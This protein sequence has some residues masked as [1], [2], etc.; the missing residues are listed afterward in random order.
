MK[1]SLAAVF[2]ALAAA[3]GPAGAAPGQRVT[4]C[5]DV[6]PI[7]YRHC[8]GCHR[9]GEVGPF[10]LLSYKD[11]AKRADFLKQVTA[12]R[13]MP[14]WK[15]EPGY[16]DFLDAR[17]LSD[18]ELHT[19]ARWADG[20]APEGDP[21]D[22]PPPPQ[23]ADGWQLGQPDLVLKMPEPFTVPAGGRDVFRC[24]VIPTGLAE[25]R[26]VAAVEF[27][28]GN[29]RVVHHALFFL[30]SL[31]AARKRDEADPGP[32]Y[33][34]FGGIGI[35]PTG[36]LGGWAPGAQPHRLPDGVGRFL[37]KNSDLVLQIHYHTTGKEEI[38]QSSV[39]STFTKKPADK[40]LMGVV[41]LNRKVDIPPGAADY[42]LTASSTLRVDVHAIGV[43]PHMHLLGREMKVKAVRPDG[44]EVPLVWIKDWDFNWQGQYLFRAPVA[45]PRG[46]RLELEAVYDNSAAN[47]K[48]P[49]NPPKRVQWGEQTTDEMCLCG[50]HV[51]ADHP[52]D[53]LVLLRDMVL[54]LADLGRRAAGGKGSQP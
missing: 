37:R 2:V 54:H 1:E 7:L 42:R 5:R 6:A 23:F 38:D 16:G 52:G 28:P 12:Q 48:N 4:Y 13:R 41:L 35:L 31:G 17:R 26:T 51:V 3:A 27:R 43:T 50:V 45:L 30:D 25:N 11:A 10:P 29:R 40:I 49:S 8:A 47:V 34:S 22:L 32:G 44:R 39:G 19:L 46:T 20:G 14:P 15:A 53:G 36:I 9:P 18:D 33:A 21:R 24:F